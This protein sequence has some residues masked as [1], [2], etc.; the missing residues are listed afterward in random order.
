MKVG[1]LVCVETGDLSFHGPP[2]DYI[3][4]IGII[5]DIP[6]S[7]NPYVRV[8]IINTSSGQFVGVCA[9]FRKSQMRILN[10]SR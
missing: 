1:D 7:Y 4:I 2:F 9:P 3:S 6:D 8:R 10:E 5:V